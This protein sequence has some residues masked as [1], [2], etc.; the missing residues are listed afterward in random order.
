MNVVDGVRVTGP[1]ALYARGFAGELVRLGFTRRSAQKQPQL[2]AHVSRWLG[3]AGRGTADL[4]VPMVDGFLA[5]RRAAGHGEFI[6]ARALAPLL[7]YLRGLG[8]APPAE[9]P[10][11]RTQAEQLLAHYR[12]WLLTERGLR[13]N[14]ARG[15]VD[16]G[17][18]VR[19]RS[20]R[21]RRGW[22]EQPRGVRGCPQRQGGRS[23]RRL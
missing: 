13:V 11:P 2:A 9:L 8:M 18:A 12:C 3:D 7:C 19:D 4:H 21:R 6:T 20:R 15:Y 10:A 23:R 17:S 22:S 16:S 1:L 5:A 14:V